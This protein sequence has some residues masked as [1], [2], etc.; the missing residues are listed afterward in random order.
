MALAA[1]LRRPQPSGDEELV[2]E[3]ERALAR[4]GRPLADGVTLAVAGAPLA[5]PPAAAAYV[6]A[7]RLARYGGGSVAAHAA[8]RRAL[9][10]QLR[11]GLGLSGRLRALWALPP[12]AAACRLP[13]T[14]DLPAA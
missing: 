9:R 11:Y 4:A 2:A 3:L 7:L 10:E 12:A 6:R 13:A 8:Q 5:L 1:A 14:T